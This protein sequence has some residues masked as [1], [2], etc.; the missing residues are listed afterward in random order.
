MGTLYAT[1]FPVKGHTAIERPNGSAWG[2]VIARSQRV[3][4]SAGPMINSATKQSKKQQKG[5]MDCFVT[6]H[7]TVIVRLA[8]FAK[9][10]AGQGDRRPRRSLGA[11]GTGRSST[12]RPLDYS[13]ASLE[14]WVA[15]SSRAMTRE[16]VAPSH[17]SNTPLHSRG[18][19]SPELC[20][21][22]ASPDNRGRRECRALDAPAASCVKKQTHEHSHHGHTGTTRHSPR[23]GFTAY[24]ALSPVTMLC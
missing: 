1:R 2:P 20:T 22:F 7:T 13:H 21:N 19:N 10:S 6:S 23:N 9:A 24:F 12:P 15:R 16:S 8:A 14:Y 4:P 3:P 17:S 18:V 5:R 11:D